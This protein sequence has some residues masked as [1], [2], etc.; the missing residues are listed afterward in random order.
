MAGTTATTTDSTTDQAA[1]R[2]FTFGLLID[3]A[4]VLEAHGYEAL[5]GRQLVELQQHLLHL[6]HGG[7]ERCTGRP[8]ASAVEAG[9]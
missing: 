8:V 5:D 3:V 7:S 2:R 4:K 1:E 9:R 6:L